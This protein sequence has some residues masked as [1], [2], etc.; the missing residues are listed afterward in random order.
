MEKMNRNRKMI[1]IIMISVFII[2]ILSTILI[3]I[4]NSRKIKGNSKIDILDVTS[5]PTES[6]TSTSTVTPSVTPSYSP[7]PSTTPKSNSSNLTNRECFQIFKDKH[8]MVAGDSMAEGLTAY[9][10]LDSSNV[11]WYRGRRIDNMKE[12]IDTIISYQPNYLFLNYGSNDLELWEGNV[13]SFIKSYRNT[14]YYLEKTLPNTKIIIN[15]IL[16]VSEKAVS[17]TPAY[18]Y[19]EL[20][21][22]KLKELAEELGIPFLENSVYLKEKENP[23][24][25]DGVH[26]KGF[27][28]SLWAKNMAEY[29]KNH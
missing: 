12:D 20:F 10:I 26:P 9:E 28:Y 24:S 5:S 7:T 2:L 15:S 21:N 16:P 27:Y 23:F 8:A 6:P 22:T 3:V 13:N 4:I 17:K 18:S 19:Q 25:Q 14:L 29:L 1:L 11:V